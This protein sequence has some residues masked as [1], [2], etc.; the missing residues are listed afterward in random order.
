MT[1]YQSMDTPC[2]G[3][4]STVYGD[5]ICRGCKRQF[6]EVIAWNRYLPE[7]KVVVFRRLEAHIAAI[8]AEFL[9]SVD[10]ILLDDLLIQHHV[11]MI[12]TVHYF[13]KAYY[14]LRQCKNNSSTPSQL[15]FTTKPA[16]INHTSKQLFT[17]VDDKLYQLACLETTEP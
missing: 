13:A 15:G 11:R 3:V 2:I 5:E 14:L 16:F 8:M 17:L 9:L 6:E 7:E 1:T 10:E 12:P 4:C